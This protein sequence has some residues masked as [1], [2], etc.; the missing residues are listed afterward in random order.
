MCEGKIVIIPF[1]YTLP[2]GLLMFQLLKR[3]N[4]GLKGKIIYRFKE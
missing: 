1:H 3:Y 4:S 2:A